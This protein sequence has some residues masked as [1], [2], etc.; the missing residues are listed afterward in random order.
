MERAGPAIR[1][2]NHPIE[3]APPVVKL[4]EI[5]TL[6]TDPLRA[7][8]YSRIKLA[9]GL[10]QTGLFFL[11]T[12]L[13][14]ATGLTA[15]IESIVRN[16]F[17]H[18][19]AVLLAFAFVL[20]AAETVVGFPL[21]VSSGYFLEHRHG[22]SNQSFG[23][24]ILEG[25]KAGLVG[26]AV[27]APVLIAL[28]WSLRNFG[29]LWWLPVGM[30]LFVFSVVLARLAPVV[31]FP[32]FYK[33]KPMEE[34]GLKERVMAICERVG[35]RI[36]G[37]FVFDMSKNTKKA[38]AAF[39]GIGK[40]RRIVLGDTLLA[41]FTDDEIE[42]VVAHELGHYKLRHLRTMILVGTAST[43]AGLYVTAQ[44][45][46]ASLNWFGFA[47]GDAV[48][49]LP[50]LG[51]W[52]ALFSFVTAPLNNIL[53]RFHERAADRFAVRLTGTKDSFA[54]ALTKLGRVNLADTDPHPLIEFLFHS[55]PSIG[56]RIKYLETVHVP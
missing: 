28:F 54:N 33:F 51:L 9:F 26:G 49:A 46:A 4:Q 8:Q 36:T 56:R 48:A 52:L 21:R 23:R 16:V 17:D 37:V 43:F 34:S 3:E 35:M 6:A 29:N 24:W 2:Q 18:D 38:N 11:L 10:A 45:Y 53:S 1:E 5:S 7:K 13:L 15:R 12:L 20:G 55:H 30:L 14:L 44:L 50:L 19:Y 39:T 40:A 27:T 32:L 41:N 42:A 25:V 47:S 22:L 31:L